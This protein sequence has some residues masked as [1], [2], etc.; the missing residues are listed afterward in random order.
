MS[1]VIRTRW[2]RQFAFTILK[3]A[4]SIGLLGFL[5]YRIDLQILLKQLGRLRLEWVLIFFLCAFMAAL[6]NAWKWGVLLRI[7]QIKQRYFALLEWTLVGLF[8][9]NVLPTGFG[10]DLMR[11]YAS[12]K[13]SGDARR[14][15]AAI[16]YDRLFSFVALVLLGVLALVFVR[17]PMPM[18]WLIYAV[19]GTLLLVLFLMTSLPFLAHLTAQIPFLKRGSSWLE[20]MQI[21]RGHKGRLGWALA[22]SAGMQILVV[23]AHLATLEALGL[24]V[25]IGDLFIFIPLIFLVVALPISINGIGLREMLFSLLFSRSGLQQGEAVAFSLTYFGLY[26]L[27]SLVGGVVY[28]GQFRKSLTFV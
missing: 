11:L 5:L 27:F 16:F 2:F 26:L 8:F 21:P 19:V 18:L 4:L 25:P 22:L 10:G 17:E 15:L 28:A 12:G 9:N 3:A 7:W 6:L 23:F 1:A 13:T 24:T 14:S 20:R